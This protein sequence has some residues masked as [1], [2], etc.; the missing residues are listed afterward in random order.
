MNKIFMI[1]FIILLFSNVTALTNSFD[2]NTT[3]TDDVLVIGGLG[4]GTS[5]PVGKLNVIGDINITNFSLVEVFSIDFDNGDRIISNDS[6]QILVDNEVR[7]IF[8]P[9]E[10]E[11][12]GNVKNI[13]DI[14]GI[15][16]FSETN[17]ND[18]NASI[19]AFSATNNIGQIFWMGI[20]GSNFDIGINDFEAGEAA[21]FLDS[22]H[23]MNFLIGH[24]TG[25][26]WR[27]NPTNNSLLINTTNILMELDRNGNLN[28]I[29]NLT[30]NNI[31][32]YV[33]LKNESGVVIDLISAGVYENIT[34]INN[35]SKLN[36]ISYDGDHAFTIDIDGTYEVS[37]SV[38]F[39]GASAKEFTFDI[40]VNGVTQDIYSIRKTSTSNAQIGA[41]IGPYAISLNVNDSLTLGVADGTTPQ[42]PTILS[43]QFGLRR[44]GQ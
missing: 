5:T 27:N 28:V 44:I 6:L 16:R 11:I 35:G 30:A 34:G 38:S 33:K 37:A 24:H 29:G 32:G 25:F 9:L 13:D 10:T 36:G 41:S 14:D 17:L 21:L 39:T 40:L 26:I 3:F 19:A 31:Y 20:S 4:V 18:G 42:D 23:K 8:G 43:V 1:F 7:A 2:G 12:T 15:S 22:P